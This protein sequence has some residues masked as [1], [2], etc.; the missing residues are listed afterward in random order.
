LDIV[1]YMGDVV[2]LSLGFPYSGSSMFTYTWTESMNIERFFLKINCVSIYKKFILL[3]IFRLVF[4]LLTIFFDRR[5]FIIILISGI[6][7]LYLRCPKCNH[8]VGLSKN[9]Y[10]TFS[11][12]GSMCKK[13]G[14]DLKKCEIEHDEI[15]DRRL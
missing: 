10:I 9:G 1:N 15:I 8:V 13:C 5:F 11:Y 4:F 12:F 6:A 7:D 14:Q 2:G 3:S